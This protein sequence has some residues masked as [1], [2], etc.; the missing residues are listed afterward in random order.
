M[1]DFYLGF[2]LFKKK[3]KRK[4]KARKREKEKEGG[5]H[6]RSFRCGDKQPASIGGGEKK[7]EKKRGGVVRNLGRTGRFEGV[8]KQAPYRPLISSTEKKEKRRRGECS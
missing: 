2:I 7:E 1:T 3:K 4:G 6:C 5:R 8:I